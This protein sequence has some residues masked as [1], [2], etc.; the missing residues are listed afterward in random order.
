MLSEITDL[1][2]IGDSSDVLYEQELLK[3]EV[4]AVFN[5]ASEI[6]GRY[7]KIRYYKYP[8][9]E[10]LRDKKTLE[11]LLKKIRSELKRKRKIVVHCYAGIDRSPTIVTCYLIMNGMEKADAW[12][13]VK[14]KRPMA[15]YHGSW[16]DKLINRQGTI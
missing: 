11:E 12:R 14:K 6:Y 16:I 2:F 10:C 13:L 1:I 9:S 15:C 4:S 3:R 8:F 7:K 5:V